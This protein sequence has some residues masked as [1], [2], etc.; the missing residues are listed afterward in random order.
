[1]STESELQIRPSTEADTAVILSMIQGLADYEKMS[2]EV[3]ATEASIRSTL[4]G[5]KPDAYCLLAFS[6]DT[7]V[8]IAIYFFNYS[9]FLARK[10]LYLEDLYVK[11][12]FRGRGYGERILRHLAGIAVAEACG[13]FEWSV[14]DWNVPAIQFYEKMG[15]TIL[16]EWRICRVTGEGL[17]QLAGHTDA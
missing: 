10:G 4:F 3:T 5:P 14:L 13:R 7:P 8:G 16:K 15:A 6:G 17:K 12:A 2:D 9:T 11:E 1:M